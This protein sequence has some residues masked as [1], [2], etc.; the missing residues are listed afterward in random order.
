[1]ALPDVTGDREVYGACPLDCPDTCSWVVTVRDGEAIALRGDRR[2]PYT[3]G[4]LCA[5]VNRFLDYTRAPDRLMY[6]QRRI[7]K[8]GEGRFTRISWDE[9]LDEIA[10]RITPTVTCTSRGTSPR[11]RPPASACPTPRSFVVSRVRSA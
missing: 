8:K 11:C 2:H 1:V 7:G 5:K 10:T 3:R 6:P 4:A 9:A